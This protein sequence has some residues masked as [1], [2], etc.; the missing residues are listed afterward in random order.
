[1][2]GLPYRAVHQLVSNFDVG[3]AIGNHVRALRKLYHR[4][5]NP[6]AGYERF[7]QVTYVCGNRPKTNGQTCW[8]PKDKPHE[9]YT[10]GRRLQVAEIHLDGVEA[11]IA[12]AYGVT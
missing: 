11:L 8:I 2:S 1:M 7:D 10:G 4:G 5:P 9:K 6:G 12:E 3:D